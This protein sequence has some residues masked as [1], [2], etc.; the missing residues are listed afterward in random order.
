MALIGYTKITKEI[1]DS[2]K[3][4]NIVV[5]IGG[6]GTGKTSLAKNIIETLDL[7]PRIINCCEEVVM[8]NITTFFKKLENQY[9]VV[10]IML[11]F[12]KRF[13]IIIDDIDLLDKIHVA[14]LF[15][16][17]I[18]PEFK[19]NKFILTC[20]SIFLKK[21]KKITENI[22]YLPKLTDKELK[23]IV[24]QLNIKVKP[25]IL[26]KIIDSYEYDIA[27]FIHNIKLNDKLSSKYCFIDLNFYDTCK[28]IFEK[29]LSFSEKDYLAQINEPLLV[30]NMINENIID[31]LQANLKKN[32]IDKII[33][34]FYKLL[35]DTN[36]YNNDELSILII[37]N[38]INDIFSKIENVKTV[39]NNFTNIY[40]QLSI[41]N[42]TD[43]IMNRLSERFSSN[44]H[45]LLLLREL[46][47]QGSNNL[48]PEIFNCGIEFED[49]QALVYINKTKEDNLKKIYTNKNFKK[50]IAEF[51]QSISAGIIS[52]N[53]S[54]S[55]NSE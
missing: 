52:S 30:K 32:E 48:D 14:E 31:Y 29:K 44:I 4:S 21:A 23:T 10:S 24:K 53:T 41:E 17:I 8:E 25:N 22:F 36:K 20:H 42:S 1:I 37:I 46:V 7:E 26:K 49:I 55:N 9:D 43:L 19:E 35:I 47:V 50:K 40:T 18:R 5:I 33:E 45:Y 13:G 38:Y 34:D 54:E 39:E 2:F 6:S 11:T 51:I 27:Q 12:K 28:A 15:K 16:N 3:N